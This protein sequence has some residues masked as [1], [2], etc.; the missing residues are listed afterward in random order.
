MGIRPG[1]PI[2]FLV[3]TFRTTDG[4]ETWD[5]G[6]GTN[7]VTVHS[8]GNA[9]VHAKDG[10]AITQHTYGR[11]GVYLAQVQRTSRHGHTA[12]ARLKIRVGGE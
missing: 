11:P 9:V 5:F 1:Q 2:K 8:D 7:K 4:E 3:R 12:T 10:Y 6:D